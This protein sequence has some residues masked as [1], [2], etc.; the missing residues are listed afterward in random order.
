MQVLQQLEAARGAI[1]Q[2]H[3]QLSRNQK[4]QEAVAAQLHEAFMQLE[5]KHKLLDEQHDSV[6]S[7]DERNCKAI[8]EI[9]THVNTF[10]T[11]LISV[12]GRQF[13]N[14]QADLANSQ[15]E[16]IRAEV[17]Q[18]LGNTY[19]AAA[20]KKMERWVHSRVTDL[21][22]RLEQVCTKVANVTQELPAKA[23]HVSAKGDEDKENHGSV[24]QGMLANTCGADMRQYQKQA[25]CQTSQQ[26]DSTDQASETQLPAIPVQ[27]HMLSPGPDGKQSTARSHN[28]LS[29]M[30]HASAPGS[31][32]TTLARSPV[33]AHSMH[34]SSAAVRQPLTKL[35]TNQQQ[36]HQRQAES[37]DSPRARGQAVAGCPVSVSTEQHQCHQQQQQTQDWDPQT[38]DAAVTHSHGPRDEAGSATARQL[39]QELQSMQEQQEKFQLE[40]NLQS[41]QQT[42]GPQHQL[43]VDAKNVLRDSQEPRHVNNA[44]HSVVIS[45][46]SESIH[47]EES[48]SLADMLE[49]TIGCK[50]DIHTPTASSR[51]AG[52][53]E[54]QAA[55]GVSLTK[56][57]SSAMNH[58]QHAWRHHRFD[59]SRN[60]HDHAAQYRQHWQQQQSNLQV[61]LPAGIPLTPVLNQTAQP[62]DSLEASIWKLSSSKGKQ[63]LP[64]KSVFGP[65]EQNMPPNGAGGTYGQ[66]PNRQKPNTR[67][68]SLHMGLTFHGYHG[69]LPEENLLGQKFVVDAT[70]FVDLQKAGKSDNVHDTVSYADVYRHIKT[71]M[72]GRPH[73]LLES[74]A[75]RLADEILNDYHMVQGLQLHLK[76][77]HVAVPG[78]VESLGI[79]ITRY[80]TQTS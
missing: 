47:A 20:G 65:Q 1:V 43:P 42:A 44:S 60:A 24:E 67:D 14:F 69:V 50:S 12:V 61:D 21:T 2:L 16:T 54:D 32:P 48:H 7:V 3:S 13:E 71:V 25:A 56:P 64:P 35:D 4:Q 70:L 52:R 26:G 5:R 46:C 51:T 23:K 19:S 41:Y 15:A 58:L 57:V 59:S 63:Q 29:L 53:R 80:R 68:K 74:V 78:V 37:A 45:P 39:D 9:R 55:S 75:D 27:K 11:E 8:A 66:Q 40:S 28:S 30:D 49:S 77:P 17:Q 76:K 18:A 38:Q 10:L 33:P 34:T 6:K 62:R 31:C 36:Q 73:K 79:E 72:E 22:Q